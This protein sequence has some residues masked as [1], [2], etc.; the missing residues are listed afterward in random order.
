MNVYV[1]ELA[2]RLAGAGVEVEVFTRATSSRQP[3]SVE[4]AT[5]GAAI[6]TAPMLSPITPSPTSLSADIE[7]SLEERVFAYRQSGP[8]SKQHYQLTT[9]GQ[10]RALSEA[11]TFVKPQAGVQQQHQ[12]WPWPAHRSAVLDELDDE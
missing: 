11:L 6:A 2:K 1:L 10:V 8:W 12:A 4:A 5:V 7:E 9:P 3:A